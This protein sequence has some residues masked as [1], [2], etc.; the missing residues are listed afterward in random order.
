MLLLFLKGAFLGLALAAPV[1]PINLLCMKRSLEQGQRAGLITGLGAA[2]ADSF[3]GAVAAFGLTF[4]SSW[5]EQHRAYLSVVGGIFFFLIGLSLFRKQVVKSVTEPRV[6][7]ARSAYFTSL[8]LTLSNPATVF[9]F[10]AAFAAVKLSTH[11]GEDVKF[12]YAAV[13]TA[14]VFAGSMLWW[15]F[16]SW[17]SSRF[18]ASLNAKAIRRIN[19]CAGVLLLIFATYVFYSGLRLLI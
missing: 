4:I 14:G 10:L 1:G 13:A 12:S 7:S 9:S 2:T 16:L 18:R 8:F 15:T 11:A 3:Y 19:L 5:L 17:I 6:M